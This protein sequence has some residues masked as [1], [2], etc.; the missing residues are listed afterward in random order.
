MSNS[1]NNNSNNFEHVLIKRP[2]VNLPDYLNI[3][4]TINTKIIKNKPKIELFPD[5][6]NFINYNLT[7]NINNSTIPKLVSDIITGILAN[8]AL[9][10]ITEFE[11]LKNNIINKS[12]HVE[13][14]ENELYLLIVILQLIG[15]YIYH[16]NTFT[17]SDPRNRTIPENLLKDE[18]FNTYEEIFDKLDLLYENKILS[19]NFK[20]SYNRINTQYGESK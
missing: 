4:H 17:N 7:K 6:I 18:E 13:K 16:M 2:I 10:N 14:D 9:T 12:T 8:N 20:Q 11:T 19:E 5:F 3:L 1:I 15:K